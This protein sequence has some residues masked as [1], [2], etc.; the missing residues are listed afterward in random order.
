MLSL[1]HVRVTILFSSSIFSTKFSI[2]S[3]S[4]FSNFGN[5]FTILLGLVLI[6][7]F[8]PTT[9]KLKLGISPSNKSTS[10]LVFTLL[11]DILLLSNF[12]DLKSL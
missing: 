4:M 5:I 7:L 1:S 3:S 6:L 8:L 2:T 11:L 10:I 12:K 9:Y